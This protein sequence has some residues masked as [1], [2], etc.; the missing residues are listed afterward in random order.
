MGWSIEKC[1][2]R[3]DHFAELAFQPRFIPKIPGLSWFVSFLVSYFADGYYSPD[4]LE[5]ILQEE[6]GKDRSILDCSNATAAGIRIGIPVTTLQDT[7]T[8]IFTNYNAIGTRPSNCG[9]F[10]I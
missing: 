8:C 4:Y 6:F 5:A 10:S 3:A 2:E 9:K 1:I 7:S